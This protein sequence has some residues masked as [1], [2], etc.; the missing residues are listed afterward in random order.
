[1]TIGEDYMTLDAMRVNE[2]RTMY[3]RGDKI[4]DIAERCGV[5]TNSVAKYSRGVM[6]EPPLPCDVEGEQWSQIPGVDGR[7][8]ISDRGRL[9]NGGTG[10]HCG[11]V[12]PRIVSK[13]YLAYSLPVDGRLWP[14]RAHVLVAKAFIPRPRPE[15]DQVNH[16]DGDKTNNCIENLEWVTQSENVSHSV[17]VLGHL[18]SNRRFTDDE[19]RAI[20]SDP[21]GCKK[22]ARAYHCGKTTILNIR[23]GKSYQEV[24]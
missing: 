20:R 15:A 11:I 21:R 6:R 2:I 1:M 24:V 19:V 22:M 7:Y 5:S 18:P 16:I 4:K 12:K 23:S 13:G 9:F 3:R 8:F 14:F 17:H 10:G